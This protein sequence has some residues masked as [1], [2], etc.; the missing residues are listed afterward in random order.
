MLVAVVGG[1]D[2]DGAGA[3]VAEIYILHHFLQ[4]SFVFPSPHSPPRGGAL[5]KYNTTLAPLSFTSL[6]QIIG[7]SSSPSQWSLCS[8]LLA[9]RQPLARVEQPSHQ[10]PLAPFPGPASAPD[11]TPLAPLPADTASAPAPAASDP[12]LRSFQSRML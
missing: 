10:T 4:T 8:L 5:N 9:A 2:D 6:K 12:P 7:S 11:Q 3:C 1:D